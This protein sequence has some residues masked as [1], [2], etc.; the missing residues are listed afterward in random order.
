MQNIEIKTRLPD[1]DRVEDALKRLDAERV[2]VRRQRDT[3]FR[4][5]RGWLKLRESEGAAELI[6]YE[7]STADTGPR[8]SS[9]D[10]LGV[11]DPAACIRLLD[12]T[13]G[14]ECVV[15]K[16]RAL[17]HHQHTR[18]HLDR[19][20]GLGDFLELE[21]VLGNPGAEGSISAREGEEEA[22]AMIEALGLDP[23]LFLAVPYRDLLLEAGGPERIR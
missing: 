15:E 19:V 21:T 7:R 16:E 5:A 1:R 20:D 14:I 22:Q 8:A 13:L 18:V 2:W 12:R 23:R 17:W 4:A 3:F 6:G 11:P 9:Y 10:L